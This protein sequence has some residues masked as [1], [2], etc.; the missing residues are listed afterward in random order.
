MIRI[1]FL[2]FVFGL[3]IMAGN[4]PQWRGLHQTGHAEESS[5]PQDFG[6]G[7]NMAW[8]TKIPGAGGSTPI[9]WNSHV[10]LT[11]TD[12]RTGKNY[13]FAVNRNSGKLLWKKA[14][15]KNFETMRRNNTASG[16]SPVTDGHL[17]VFHFGGGE[18]VAFDFRGRK[19]WERNLREYGP[20]YYKFGYASTPV[21]HDG[22]LYFGVIRGW[23]FKDEDAV[24]K[25]HIAYLLCLDMKTGK[26]IWK[27]DRPAASTA[28]Q[29]NFQTYASPFPYTRDGKTEI[30]IVGGDYVSGHNPSNGKSVWHTESYNTENETTWRVI[31][32]PTY[33]GDSIYVSAARG[34][35]MFAIPGG[36][37]GKIPL[38][39]VNWRLEDNAP[40]VCV[41]LSYQN[42]LYVLDGKKK[43][44]TA[45]DP[46]TGKIY[47]TETFD[48]KKRSPLIFSSP[49]GGDGKIYFQRVNGDVYVIKAGRKWKILNKISLGEANL[50]SNIA[51]SDGQIFI[52]S[53]KSLFCFGKKS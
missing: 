30:V 6:P 15:G 47:Y 39:E 11:G 26:T 42:I 45:I 13:A 22:K 46:K 10:F 9:I 51:I 19:V 34:S 28:T 43:T 14:V 37:K 23:P 49:T 48:Q 25:D 35:S 40:D 50:G 29:E 4:W 24:Q 1:S 2:I 27:K 38:S 53:D 7:K 33:A 44:M 36:R 52:R 16:A 17:V 31:A 21:L 20:L 18:I 3:P 32:S 5:L 12:L 8:K 41:P